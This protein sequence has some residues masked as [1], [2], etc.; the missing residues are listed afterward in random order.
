MRIYPFVLLALIGCATP[1]D[2]ARERQQYGDSLRQRCY[3]YGFKP[4]EQ[5]TANCIM[6]LDLIVQQQRASNDAASTAMALQLLGSS[7]PYRA[8][9]GVSCWRMG[10]YLQCR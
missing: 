7:Q 10:D 3:A 8:T 6:Q 9:G 2:Q 5:A 1:E 4:G